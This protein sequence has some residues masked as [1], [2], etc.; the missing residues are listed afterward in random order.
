MKRR[1]GNRVP[2]PARCRVA[3][4]RCRENPYTPAPAP[5]PTTGVELEVVSGY[6]TH[7][8]L[9]DGQ[10]AADQP[11]ANLAG[12]R[13]GV[14]A[15]RLAWRAF[16]QRL[17][18]LPELVAPWPLIG[19]VTMAGP[20]PWR[21]PPAG[22]SGSASATCPASRRRVRTSNDGTAGSADGA[23]GDVRSQSGRSD[24][25]VDSVEHAIDLQRDGVC[26]RAAATSQT[27]H[28]RQPDRGG[29]EEHRPGDH[30]EH[31]GAG[32]RHSGNGGA[33]RCA[34]SGARLIDLDAHHRRP[35]SRVAGTHAHAAYPSQSP[36]T[37]R[38]AHR[39]DGAPDDS[40]ALG[41]HTP[42]IA[43]SVSSEV[44]AVDE[45]GV[46]AGQDI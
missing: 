32:R 7:L 31:D 44:V 41:P 30:R 18:L 6:L 10:L 22:R 11:A 36:F 38:E 45:P 14:V 20:R 4:P 8:G 24:T 40:P 1:P 29:D 34:T 13:L 35:S 5:P 16:A 42:P 17:G 9:S 46:K 19:V 37:S 15:G 39:A 23:A 3:R 26:S 28:S 33:G 25:L 27:D 2:V 21:G 12:L 43:E